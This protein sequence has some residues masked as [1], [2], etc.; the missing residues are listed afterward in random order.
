MNEIKYHQV[1]S[2]QHK[3]KASALIREYLD[4]LNLKVQHNYGLEF[5]VDAM[6]DSDLTDDD[7]FSP[8]NGRF[9]LVK[10]NNQTAGV[11]CLKK[12]QNR[13]GEIQRMYVLPEFRG[14]G[15]GRAIVNR[16]V[17][18]A[19]LIGYSKLKL[20]SLEFLNSAHALYRSIGFKE[21][22][23]Y[24]KNSMASF[25]AQEQLDKYYAITVFM[26]MDI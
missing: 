18:D 2:Q 23:P 20:E 5:D 16:L 11:G 26:E 15:I 12:L 22:N 4:Y 14:H 6:V 24:A 21:I 8:P 13:V 25:Q 3:T 1:K 19:R 7:K 10:F 9:Y 17:D